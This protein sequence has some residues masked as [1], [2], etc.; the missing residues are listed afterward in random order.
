MLIV[1]TIYL[2]KQRLASPAPDVTPPFSLEPPALV[3]YFRSAGIEMVHIIDLD[4]PPAT[5]PIIDEA[6]IK[7]FATAFHCSISAK[8]R[9]TETMQ[10]YFQLGVARFILGPLAYQQPSLA[11][12]AAKQF[13]KKIGVEIAVRH[14]KVAIPGWIVAANK[15][16]ADYAD[17][18]REMGIAIAH[19]SD[20]DEMGELQ[21]DNFRSI[22]EF[23]QHARMP[24]VHNADLASL[25]QLRQLFLLEKFGIMATI[26]GTSCYDGRFDLVSLVTLAKEYEQSIESD[27]TTLVPE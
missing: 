25:E 18:F 26:L 10:R 4:A 6:L 20:V 14:G 11:S 15:T 12:N 2:R 9:A 3:E 5:G 16:A 23:A 8:T 22:R 27:E 21:S 24:I 7:L 1:P 19:Y 17:R 13:P